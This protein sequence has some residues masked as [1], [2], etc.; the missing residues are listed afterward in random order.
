VAECRAVGTRLA[1]TRE[2]RPNRLQFP[3]D[4]D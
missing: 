1:V 3:R 2:K 4:L